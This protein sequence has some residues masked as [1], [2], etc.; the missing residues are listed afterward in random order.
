M[1]LAD[2]TKKE[3]FLA[4]RNHFHALADTDPD[5]DWREHW[6]READRIAVLLIA[7]EHEGSLPRPEEVAR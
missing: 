1:T 7:L 6:N 2:L 4:I 5:P 3:R